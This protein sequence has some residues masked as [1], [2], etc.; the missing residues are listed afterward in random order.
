MEQSLDG[1]LLVAGAG[2]FDPNF[3]QTVILMIEHSDGVVGR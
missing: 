2:L 1:R 3:R